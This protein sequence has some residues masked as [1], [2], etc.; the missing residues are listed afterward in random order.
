MVRTLLQRASDLFEILLPGI[1][2]HGMGRGEF[3]AGDESRIGAEAQL[4]RATDQ[5]RQH[6]RGNPPVSLESSGTALRTSI[7]AFS[8]NARAGCVASTSA[9]PSRNAWFRA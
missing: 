9:S 4:R 5:T 3:D 8:N 1:A 2:N 7:G 6:G